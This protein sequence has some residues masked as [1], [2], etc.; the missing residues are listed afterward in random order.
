MGQIKGKLP[1]HETNGLMGFS[2]VAGH[3]EENQLPGSEHPTRAQERE[4]P[5][6][7][8]LTTQDSKFSS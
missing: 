8:T 1:G 3:I 6:S 2:Y 7:V 4:S 5:F